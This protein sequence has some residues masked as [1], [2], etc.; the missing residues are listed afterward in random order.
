MPNAGLTPYLEIDLC[1]SQAKTRQNPSEGVSNQRSAIIPGTPA[2]ILR[3]AQVDIPKL[4]S[5]GDGSY[6]STRGRTKVL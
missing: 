4:T 6:T 3:N 1:R 5:H 2:I